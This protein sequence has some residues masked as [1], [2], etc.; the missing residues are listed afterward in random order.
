MEN[1][2]ITYDIVEN[3]LGENKRYRGYVHHSLSVNTSDLIDEIV[4]SNTTLTRQDALG[5]IDLYESLIK[6]HL[7]EGHT[8]NTGLF[9]A[10]LS[11]K[12]SFENSFDKID[13][14]KHKPH[15]VIRPSKNLNK[16]VCKGLRFHRQKQ[17]RN[18][19]YI[20][21]CIEEGRTLPIETVTAGGILLIK[22]KGL[23]HYQYTN[24]YI[25][26]AKQKGQMVSQLR[27]IKSSQGSIR[28]LVPPDLPPGDYQLELKHSYGKVKRRH[29]GYVKII[30]E[31]ED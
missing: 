12:G 22:G 7:R 29:H 19:H 4:K 1:D 27:I 21:H 14:N 6:R 20:D 15:I 11:M 30:A 2:I 9:R 28:A 23:K 17:M 26:T 31:A 24:H 5:V 18:N 3:A 16:E 8:V 25:L 10:D 13:I